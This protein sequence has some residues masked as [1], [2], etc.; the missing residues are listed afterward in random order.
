M[1]SQP[2][3]SNQNHKRPASES[4]GERPVSLANH[5]ENQ[6]I[7]SRNVLD[8]GFQ[9]IIAPLADTMKS[10]QQMMQQSMQ[11]QQQQQQQMQLQQQQIDRIEQEKQQL[12]AAAAA[13]AQTQQIQT[14]AAHGVA[15]SQPPVISPA[16]P[17]KDPVPT[18]AINE[19][20]TAAKTKLT[21]TVNQLNRFKAKIDGLSTI[22]PSGEHF[23][24]YHNALPTNTPGFV[25]TCVTG[26][27]YIPKELEGNERLSQC[28]AAVK[29]AE[30]AL[31]GALIAGLTASNEEKLKQLEIQ[32]LA[33]RTDL[34]NNV[35]AHLQ[36]INVSLVSPAQKL[37]HVNA[38]AK[39][40]DDFREAEVL[41]I[42]SKRIKNL[43]DHEEK[44][45][46]LEDE[47][48]RQL[49]TT[50]SSESYAAATRAVVRQEL[51]IRVLEVGGEGMDED[52]ETQVKVSNAA[53]AEKLV[54][55]IANSQSK[56]GRAERARKTQQS[57]KTRGKPQKEKGKAQKSKQQTR[58][59][60]H[61]GAGATK[62]KGNGGRGAH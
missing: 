62:P 10:M 30:R 16:P 6:A 9:S 25:K 54:N 57:S 40:Y 4:L 34:V 58:K 61:V 20:I 33:I 47:K 22:D 1:Q 37:L 21:L 18:A 32:L 2:L 35:T 8:A 24:N 41:K 7:A 39:L 12:A 13:V 38:A 31:Q 51:A 60:G 28:D 44:K 15:G 53:L 14:A 23:L 43:K 36:E 27:V 42:E 48:L 52:L 46:E 17:S 55:T 45:K 56:N 3:E 59:G 29:A 19:E 50:S 5:V 11:M 26:S 49:E